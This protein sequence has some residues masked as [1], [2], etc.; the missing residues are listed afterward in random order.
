MAQERAA[1]QRLTKTERWNID[2][3]NQAL[4]RGHVRDCVGLI[5]FEFKPTHDGYFMWINARYFDR[6]MYE[7]R[8]NGYDLKKPSDEFRTT[9]LTL[10]INEDEPPR[11][12]LVFC[13]WMLGKSFRISFSTTRIQLYRTPS[14]HCMLHPAGWVLFKRK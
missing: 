1:N 9:P 6:I 3:R 7:I 10:T 14:V 5:L 12:F 11:K 4:S 8:Q 13:R 2:Q